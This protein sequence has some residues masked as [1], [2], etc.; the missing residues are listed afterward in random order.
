MLIVIVVLLTK[1]LPIFQDVYASLGGSLT[2]IAGGLLEFGRILNQSLPIISIVLGAAV[3]IP[4]VIFLIPATSQ[5]TKNLFSKLF[6]D[7]G[8]QKKLNN[9]RFADALSIA[10]SSGI[11]L[12]ECI[13]HAAELLK[14][15]K[16][17][18][19]RIC[20]CKELIEEG[21]ELTDALF[22]CK[23]LSRS[24]CN[25]LAVA[26]RAGRGDTVMAQIAARMSDEAQDCLENAVSKIEPALVIIT[27]FIVG[28][29]LLSVMLPLINIMKAI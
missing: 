17:A 10:F 6:G 21:Y 14:D 16:P 3:I 24:S 28:I 8:I 12:D 23:F 15:N 11:P 18:Y 1:V 9:A 22:R 4:C 20:K 29:I 19:Q 2:G 27:S 25:L 7:K 26:I 5:A 13:D